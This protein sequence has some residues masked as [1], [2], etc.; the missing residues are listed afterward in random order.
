MPESPPGLE[1]PEQRWLA[2]LLANNASRA[3]GSDDGQRD[4]HDAPT[5]LNHGDRLL[6]EPIT[7]V[8]AQCS[9]VK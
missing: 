4:K 7:N 2:E 9:T 1:L 3:G 5:W 8:G 6:E